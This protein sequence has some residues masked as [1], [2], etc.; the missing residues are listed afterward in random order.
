[1][2]M[3][4]YPARPRCRS[5]RAACSCLDW[6]ATIVVLG[7]ARSLVRGCP[8]NALVA[9]FHGQPGAG[10]DCRRGRHGR[11]DAADDPPHRPAALSRRRLHRRQRRPCGTRIE[12]VPV[13]GACDHAGQLVERHQ[14]RQIL[15]MQGELA[16][17]QLRKLVDDARHGGCEVRVLPNYR[18]LIEGSVTVQPRPVSIEDLLAT[19]AGA[20]GHR[21]HPPVDRRA[22]DSGDRQRRQHRLGNLPAVAAIRPATDRAGRSLGDGP[23]LPG[24][25][26]AAP[27]RRQ[28][29][30]RL[31]R[32]RA[33]RA[34][35]A[36][37]ADALPAARDLPRRRLQTRSPDGTPSPGSGAKH[38]QGHPPAGRPG[39]RF[40]APTRW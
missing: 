19:R 28:A 15:V 14:V 36:P 3:I 27:G 11:L 18:Q 35:H 6:G 4:Q 1:M 7:G 2:A 9:V 29:D 22:G 37:R 38:R 26:I 8:R 33:R 31:H 23:V 34:S 10:A 17:P 20:V 25:G 21:G 16:G 24:T 13:L 39:P 40:P 30:R 5:S 12:G 32:R